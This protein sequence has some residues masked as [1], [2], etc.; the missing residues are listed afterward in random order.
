[1]HLLST[2][3][4]TYNRNASQ[5]ARCTCCHMNCMHP[6][7]HLHVHCM[8]LAEV[9]YVDSTV[10]A[11]CLHHMLSSRN[12][13]LEH[14]EYHTI[15]PLKNDKMN[16]AINQNC[17]CI[18]SGFNNWNSTQLKLEENTHSLWWRMV[19]TPPPIF[20]VLPAW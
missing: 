5:V 14:K 19:E 7:L 8:S 18:K 2:F 13:Q 9:L 4:H 11:S 3:I 20:Q 6:A 10:S 17:I 12:H 15:T 1:M 16:V